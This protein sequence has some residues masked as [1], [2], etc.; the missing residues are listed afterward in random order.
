[1]RAAWAPVVVAAVPRAAQRSPGAQRRLA[2]EQAADGQVAA[3]GGAP[4]VDRRGHRLVVLD[5]GEAA[6]GPREK[7]AHRADREALEGGN[8][9]VAIEVVAVGR[10]HVGPQPQAGI[11][12][13]RARRGSPLGKPLR[14]RRGGARL[15]QLLQ[16]ERAGVLAL[17]T[18]RK[19]GLDHEMVVVAG[20]DH[21]L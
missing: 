16:G 19:P 2:V 5:G 12:D 15:D 18:H 7:A 14:D 8:R 21:E 9:E 3:D 1:M 10:I 13:T 17:A 6:R 4:R 20:D 11:G